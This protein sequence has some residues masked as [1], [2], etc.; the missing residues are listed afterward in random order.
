[1]SS[2]LE[3]SLQRSKEQLQPSLATPFD[4]IALSFSGGGFR[5]AS[6]SLGVLSYFNS[7]E[8]DEEDGK[9]LLDHVTYLSSASGGTIAT[10]LYSYYNATG[11]TFKEFYSKLF[12]A[13]DGDG[14]LKNTLHILNT[15]A[16]WRKRSTKNR[17]LIN[18]FSLAYDQY[19]FD[20]ATLGDLAADKKEEAKIVSHLEEVCFNTTEFVHGLLFHQQVKLKKDAGTDPF[21][22][23]GNFLGSLNKEVSY[24]IRLGDIMAA[25]S[26]FPGGFEPIVFPHDFTNEKL[27]K[28]EL[29]KGLNISPQKDDKAERAFLKHPTFGLMDGGISDNQGLESMMQAQTRRQEGKT[30]F[31]PFDLVL[32]SDV[33][34]H[35][36][37]PYEVPVAKRK[38]SIFNFSLMKFIALF[39]FILV[40]SSVFISFSWQHDYLTLIIISSFFAVSSFGILL[41]MYL[42]NRSLRGA[43]KKTSGF[44][45]S[46]TFG[47]EVVKTLLRFLKNTPVKV[48]LQMVSARGNSMFTLNS[49]VFLKRIRQLLYNSFYDSPV[50]K[51][52][53]KSN[54]VYDLSFSNDIYRKKNDDVNPSL[55]PSREIQIIAETAYE[56][57]TTLWFEENDTKKLHKEACLVSCGQ[58][59]TCYNLLMY[60]MKL[61][62]SIDMKDLDEKYQTRLQTLT[63]KLSGDYEKFKVDPFFLFNQLA[64]EYSLP[65][66][67]KA[68]KVGDI[69]FPENFEGI[70]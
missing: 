19:L 28:E 26:C 55:K 46:K 3:Q 34:S 54:H 38:W 44:N 57:G 24:K 31:K 17:N 39:S 10:A 25:S 43:A 53:G 67:E 68:V 36:M 45:L 33:A 2:D 14:L 30:T 52:R 18:A 64:V 66:K 48:L 58:F 13:L 9:T 15:K 70:R 16:Y 49:D 69:P 29:R 1:M 27:S 65:G 4:S 62:V 63:T 7:I 21:F 59:T 60:V 6:Y 8:L 56:M 50:W 41:M 5:A 35:Y 11:K 22:F 47:P 40:F 42:S 12:L 32:V 23:Y 20:G 61:Q 37:S 51:N